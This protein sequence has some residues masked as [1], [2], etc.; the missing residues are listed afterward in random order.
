MPAECV[1][2]ASAKA[3]GKQAPKSPRLCFAKPLTGQTTGSVRFTGAK[4][5]KRTGLEVRGNG[6]IPLL[7]L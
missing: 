2:T 4:K 6:G 5:K 1:L 3:P 7:D